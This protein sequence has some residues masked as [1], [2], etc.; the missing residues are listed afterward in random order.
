MI[1]LILLETANWKIRPS[2]A[3]L[4]FIVDGNLWEKKKVKGE[5]SNSWILSGSKDPHWCH[6]L[7]RKK[8]REVLALTNPIFLDGRK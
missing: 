8:D 7:L 5:G 4:E 1:W 2:N 6:V 3:M